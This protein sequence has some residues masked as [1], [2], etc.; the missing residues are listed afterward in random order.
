MRSTNESLYAS[1]LCEF[2]LVMLYSCTCILD[3]FWGR[4]YNKFLA[5]F[6]LQCYSITEHGMAWHRWIEARREEGG[7][8]FLYHY[9]S[10]LY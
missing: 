1:T 9:Y 6:G 3:T 4:K 2:I 5:G 7:Y 8:P 10:H